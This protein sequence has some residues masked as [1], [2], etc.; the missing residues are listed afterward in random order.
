M[1]TVLPPAHNHIKY[2]VSTFS[3]ETSWN[4]TPSKQLGNGIISTVLMN[5]TPNTSKK[6]KKNREKKARITITYRVIIKEVKIQP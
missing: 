4:E 3:L 5:K 1:E 2:P 6:K